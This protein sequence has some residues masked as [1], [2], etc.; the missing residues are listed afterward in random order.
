MQSN[1][2]LVPIGAT[3]V[4]PLPLYS[5]K[6]TGTDQLPE[7][8][9]VAI[10]NDPTN[11]ARALLV[12][13]S[14]KLI[15]LAGGGNS[16]STPAGIESGRIEVIP[17]DAVAGRVERRPPM[18]L[19]TLLPLLGTAFRQTVIMVL[20]TL[21]AGG[22]AAWRSAPPCTRPGPATWP[23]TRSSSRSST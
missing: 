21:L 16:L 19:D 10:P 2:T 1:Q 20:I 4:Y 12:L 14:A 23:R 5:T 9:K 22:V 18:T 3:A 11:Q 8:A 17:V 7:G 6:H 15:T 13:Q